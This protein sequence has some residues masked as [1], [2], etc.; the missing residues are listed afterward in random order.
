MAG[1]DSRRTNLGVFA[2]AIV[3]TLSG[4]ATYLVGTH[5]YWWLFWTHG[6][7]GLSLLAL[8][9]WKGKV[10]LRG[11]RK[12][13][14]SVS[15]VLSIIT[16]ALLLA[17]IG[18]GVWSAMAQGGSLGP[19]SML[20][21]HV[22]GALII[23]PLFVAHLIGRWV[24]PAKRDLSRRV[25]LKAGTLVGAGAALRLGTD[26]IAKVAGLVGGK[27]RFTGSHLIGAPGEAFPHVSWLFEDPDPI[28]ATG[29]RL[30]IAGEVDTE[31]SLSYAD[32]TGEAHESI[33]ATIDCT[34][35]WYS[36]QDWDGVR[37]GALL[38]RAGLRD[39]V[40]S[41]V[42]TSV[43]GYARA[44]PVAEARELL[45]ATRVAG[46]PLE[47][48]HGFPARV[49]APGRRGYWWVKWVTEIE[50]SAAPS[51]LQPPVPLQ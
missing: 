29:W 21:L 9:W 10:V 1:F 31:L 16:M 14:P 26:G 19:W 40:R 17:I 3:S 13:W 20:E 45:L 48:G 49:V 4:F 34:G 39:G 11:L 32:V 25:L 44:Y 36:A 28:D 33:R 35:G 2:I 6:A 24:P 27:R 47:H 37:V 43:S 51:W 18:T 23:I 30:A 22:G 50:A 5:S 12:R 7:I 41:I 46:R 8:L 38:D 42:F 15:A